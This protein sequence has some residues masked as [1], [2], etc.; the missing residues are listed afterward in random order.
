MSDLGHIGGSGSGESGF[1][2]KVKLA[3]FAGGLSVYER[4]VAVPE[5]SKASALCRGMRPF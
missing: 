1:N 2:V 3:G 4:E 5:K